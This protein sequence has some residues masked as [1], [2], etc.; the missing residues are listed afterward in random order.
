MD[1]QSRKHEELRAACDQT[2]ER[3]ISVSA[4]LA[5]LKVDLPCFSGLAVEK[6]RMS[7][8]LILDSAGFVCMAKSHE[9]GLTTTDFADVF[10]SWSGRHS[11]FGGR[12]FY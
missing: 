3:P 5:F 4:I 7:A 9:A 8:L 2:C 6:P 11:V 1:E 12:H 10:V